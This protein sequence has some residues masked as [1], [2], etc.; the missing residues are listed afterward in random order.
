VL[1]WRATGP[2]HLLEVKLEARTGALVEVGVV[3]VPPVRVRAGGSLQSF[4]AGG[5]CTVG[6]PS[7]VTDAWIVRT[8]GS[9]LVDPSRRRIDE[10]VPFD[11]VVCGD[12]LI[13]SFTRSGPGQTVTEGDASFSFDDR[14]ELSALSV[15]LTAEQVAV[16]KRSLLDVSIP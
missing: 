11:L 7:F 9:E 3:L 4:E 15:R 8:R 2:N 6:H 16:L 1:Y 12:G 13:V 14:Q 10:D 5:N